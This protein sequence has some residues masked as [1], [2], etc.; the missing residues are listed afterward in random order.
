LSENNMVLTRVPVA[1]NHRKQCGACYWF[2]MGA[3]G[4]NGICFFNPPV[5]VPAIAQSMVARPGTPGQMPTVFSMRPPT[6]A[7]A[8]CRH[9]SK[10]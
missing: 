9:W 4:V 7:N 2:E 5:P 8:R 10:S 1:L 6:A 3:D